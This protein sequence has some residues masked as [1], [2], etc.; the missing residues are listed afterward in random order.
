MNEKAAL[1]LILADNY[2][3]RVAGKVST[4]MLVNDGRQ[5]QGG[6]YVLAYFALECRHGGV[7]DRRWC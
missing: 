7:F 3:G 5:I 1:V 6:E 2:G 4:I